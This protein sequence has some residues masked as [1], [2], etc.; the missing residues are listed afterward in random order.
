MAISYSLHMA[1]PASPAA[2]AHALARLAQDAGLFGSTATAQLVLEEGVATTHGTWIRVIDADPQP[3]DSVR[4]DFGFTPAVLAIFRFKKSAPDQQDDDMIHL[5]SGLLDR[6]PSS[7]AIL[8]FDY[9]EVWLL[10]R[11]A[12]LTLSEDDELWPSHRLAMLTRPYRRTTHH[13][14]ME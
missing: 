8:H 1:A 3:W 14:S 5:V 6:F 2:V 13:F 11:G 7:D 10:H 9:E 12:E 4:R